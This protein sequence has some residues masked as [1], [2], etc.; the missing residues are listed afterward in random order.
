MRRNSI[1]SFY[2]NYIFRI[3][4]DYTIVHGSMENTK[5]I[6]SRVADLSRLSFTENES[7]VFEQQFGKILDYIQTIE[8]Y[9]LSTIE[10][11]SS[12]CNVSDNE[13]DDT[14]FPSLSIDEALSNAPKRNETFFKVPK[15]IQK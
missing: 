4:T 7:E 8:K 10:P 14:V 13:R 15:V 12:V 6:V 3:F 5:Q 1:P 9:E 2:H 11:L